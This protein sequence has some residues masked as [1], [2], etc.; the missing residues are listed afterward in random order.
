MTTPRIA[1]VAALSLAVTGSWVLAKPPPAAED[2]SF[3]APPD[4]ALVVF[5]RDRAGSRTVKFRVIDKKL[6]CLT[7]FKQNRH[8]IL[9]LEPGEHVLY[10]AAG[11]RRAHLE[12]LQLKLAAGRT[13]VIGA[14]PQLASK[15]KVDL[16]T[17]RR[18]T[19]RFAESKD[20]IRK[21]TRHVPDLKR[22]QKRIDRKR[23]KLESQVRDVDRGWSGTYESYRT[24]H[25][26]IE[27]DGRTAEEAKGL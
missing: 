14:R 5:V 9:E 20:W 4:K 21:T 12:R 7:E 3:V 25:S 1:L 8:V 11:T 13:Y 26:V 22:C 23:A 2:A 24:A 27:E 15:K 16:E 18:N 17:V 10:V 6:R 19:E